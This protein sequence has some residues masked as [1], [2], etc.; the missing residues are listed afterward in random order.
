MC[1]RYFL[2]TL[3]ELMLQHFGHPAPAAYQPHWNIAPTQH[4]PVLRQH[5][6]EQELAMLRWGLVPF[7][8]K[9]LSIGSR[10]INARSDGIAAKPA[11]RG[12]YRKRRCVV[13]ASGFYEW[14]AIGTVK[15]PYA[16]VPT[17]AACFGLAGLWED[18]TDPAGSAVETFTIVTTEANAKMRELHQRMPVILA[19]A[20]YTRWISGTTEEAATLM[21]PCPDEWVRFFPVSRAVNNA[22]N[23]QES[24]VEPVTI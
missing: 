18:W 1:G 15:Q 4:A 10:L 16:I 14:A 20:D 3:P 24:L 23:D 19:P 5:R 12:A 8:A 22:R 2:D 21:G 13:P 9:E 11:F 6:R 7:W 17:N